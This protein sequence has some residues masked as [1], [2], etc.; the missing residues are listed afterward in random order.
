MTAQ[1]AL[2]A[3]GAA[4]PMTRGFQA[5]A[6]G[7]FAAAAAEFLSRVGAA[8][9]DYEARYWLASALLGGG[10]PEAASQAMDDARNLQAVSVIRALGSDMSRFQNDPA[11]CTELGRLLYGNNLMGAG[12]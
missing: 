11:Y 2:D 3:V 5:M 12:R 4:D 7:E 10:Q 9:A 6:R 8:P 1:T